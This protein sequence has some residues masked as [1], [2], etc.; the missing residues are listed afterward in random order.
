[1]KTTSSKVS[2]L[3]DKAIVNDIAGK[4]FSASRG[5]RPVIIAFLYYILKFMLSVGAYISRAF[6]R[7]KLGERTY[8]IITIIFIYLLLSFVQITIETIDNVGPELAA[9]NIN[10]LD[11]ASLYDVFGIYLLVTTLPDVLQQFTVIGNASATGG[12]Y[13]LFRDAFINYNGLVGGLKLLW[14][15]ILAFSA[16]HFIELF[17]RSRREEVVHSFHRGRSGFFWRLS[18]K[19]IVGFEIKDIYIWMI[20]EPLFIFFYAIILDF[21]F[22]DEVLSLVLKFSAFCLLLEEYMVYLENKS[23]ALDIIDSIIDGKKLADI[24]EKYTRDISYQED[25]KPSNEMPLNT[26]IID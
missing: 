12:V 2:R 5:R 13:F 10:D 18:G 16:M 24:Q 3:S 22:G 21:A 8:G 25:Q 20:L 19:K 6:L 1:M 4:V 23:M 26:V 17:I 7:S 15:V 14:W 11:R 9:M